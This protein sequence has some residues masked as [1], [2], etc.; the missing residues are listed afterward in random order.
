MAQDSGPSSAMRR[1]LAWALALAAAWIVLGVLG[2]A[3]RAAA[4]P[5][6]SDA[7]RMLLGEL[8]GD[9]SDD[10]L[11]DAV[12]DVVESAAE[13]VDGDLLEDVP[14]VGSPLATATEG[15]ETLAE[16]VLGIVD[17]AVAVVVDDVVDPVTEVVDA[18]APPID[19]IDPI[20]PDPILPDPALPSPAAPSPAPPVDGVLPSTDD[21]SSVAVRAPSAGADGL[22]DQRASRGASPADLIAPPAP[23]AGEP[24][25]S[26]DSP[27]ARSSSGPFGPAAAGGGAT[28]LSASPT[29]SPS[30]PGI[31]GS[32]AD[33]ALLRGAAIG[34]LDTDPLTGPTREH[35]P[36]PD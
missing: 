34:A 31:L 9:G 25:A 3:E 24:V 6:S 4:A 35:P 1:A 32:S 15:V 18:V 17:D 26:S 19:V 23:R 13:V 2:P 20:L 21:D 11:G 7:H 16:P 28:A 36:T 8:L 30:S 10:D 14:L 12:V 22:Q 33:P 27:P 29:P 5:A